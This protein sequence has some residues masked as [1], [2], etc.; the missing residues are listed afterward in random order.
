MSWLLFT[1]CMGGPVRA[2]IAI[3]VAPVS[4]QVAEDLP[5]PDAPTEELP[6]AL[7]GGLSVL[8]GLAILAVIARSSRRVG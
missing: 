3:P 2:D 8:G 4:G 6:P 7:L 1:L 5:S